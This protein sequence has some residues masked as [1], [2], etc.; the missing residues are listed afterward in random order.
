VGVGVRLADIEKKGNDKKDKF[1]TKTPTLTMLAKKYDTTVE[2]VALKVFQGIKV[3]REHTGDDE[4]AMEIAMDH[5]DEMFDYYDK[6]GK[7]EK[8]K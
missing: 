1:G 4:L 8:Q 7:M 5:I 3:E 6:L 2:K